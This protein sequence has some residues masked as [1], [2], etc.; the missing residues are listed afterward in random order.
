MTLSLRKLPTSHIFL[1]NKLEGAVFGQ[2]FSRSNA[3]DQ[4]LSH[5]HTYQFSQVHTYRFSQVHIYQ[6][7]EEALQHPQQTHEPV[8]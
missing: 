8:D 1:M 7:E 4:G 6:W 2:G 3:M 5:P